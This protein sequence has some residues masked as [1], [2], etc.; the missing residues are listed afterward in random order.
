MKVKSNLKEWTI[1]IYANG[2]NEL[3]P[4]IYNSKLKAE[5]VGSTSN[6]NVVMEIGLDSMDIPFIMRPNQYISSFSSPWMGVRRYYINRNNS[7]L[8]EDLGKINMADHDN[9][10]DFIAWGIKNYPA[11]KYMLIISGH[12]SSFVGVLPDFSQEA[13]YIMGVWEMCYVINKVKAD[14]NTNIDI[15][16][17]DMCYMNYLELVYELGKNPYPTV[18][19]I[20]TYISTCPLQGIPYNTIIKILEEHNNLNN[21]NELLKILIDEINENLIAINVNHGKLKRIKNLSNSIAHL[22][23]SN[24][25]KHSKEESLN[26]I[27]KINTKITSLIIYLNR[28]S[29]FNN[30]PIDIISKLSSDEPLPSMLLDCYDKFSFANN[31]YWT[32]LLKDKTLLDPL[33]ITIPKAKLYMLPKDSFKCLINA[34]NINL[35]EDETDSIVDEIFDF[36]KWN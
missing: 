6:I 28:C 31:N 18:R 25:N 33:N 36:K 10:Y 15:L 8:I 21:T 35:D 1:L 34:V 24:E 16:V 13:P 19:N 2:N 5:K 11:Q 23:L 32:S 3:L 20:L 26:Y 9:L 17:L 12:G 14:T 4:E 30:K 7:T 29:E 27:N 22:L